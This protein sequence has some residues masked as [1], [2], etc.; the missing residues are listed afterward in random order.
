MPRVRVS[1][2][3][4]AGAT[5]PTRRPR[6]VE[7][8]PLA[9]LPR[10]DQHRPRA[11]RAD[12]RSV[13]SCH[14]LRR[15]RRLRSGAV[16]AR[17]GASLVE[18]A[19]GPTPDR[20]DRRHRDGGRL[21]L[22]GRRASRASARPPPSSSRSSTLGSSR[23]T[24]VRSRACMGLSRGACRPGGARRGAD[25]GT[26][27]GHAHHLRHRRRGTVGRHRRW[28]PRYGRQTTCSAALRPAH[29]L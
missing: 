24:T 6:D 9:R 1:H 18:A 20:R 16:R 11:G 29:G 10:C 15:P 2:D 3:P 25:R 4:Q 23:S 21:P 13:A 8:L 12:R 28:S 19:S 5:W 27:H 22:C 7:L 17:T 14:P 26:C